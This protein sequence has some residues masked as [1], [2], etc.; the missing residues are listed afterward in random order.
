VSKTDLSDLNKNPKFDLF[1]T[2][3]VLG[4]P[5]LSRQNIALLLV[6]LVGRCWVAD[7][8]WNISTSLSAYSVLAETEA[9]VQ[10]TVAFA[11]RH[12]LRLVVKNTGH[13]WCVGPSVPTASCLNYVQTLLRRERS[14]G[15][16]VTQLR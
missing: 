15:A 9:D 13:D 11:A 8:T 2:T 5:S 10:A 16:C 3:D 7:G 12:N 6:I 14:L 1:S 4:W